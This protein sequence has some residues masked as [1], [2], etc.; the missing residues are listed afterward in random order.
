MLLRVLA[1][2]A[3]RVSHGAPVAVLLFGDLNA[4]K[5]SF[6]PS[7]RGC[8]PQAAYRLIRDGEIRRED[9]DWRFSI[10]QPSAEGTEAEVAPT[11]NG[12]CICCQDFGVFPGLGVCP[13]CDGEGFGS[14]PCLSLHLQRP[15]DLEDANEHLEVTNFTRDFQECLD[16]ILIDRRCLRVAR[17][18]P[19]PSLEALRR[20]TALPSPEFPSDHIPVFAEIDFK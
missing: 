12:R 8:C 7:D 1:K 13:L 4:R 15:L 6:G 3:A 5:G 2:E 17:R 19:A 10:W 14:E 9:P 18:F 20:H 11:E 16:Y